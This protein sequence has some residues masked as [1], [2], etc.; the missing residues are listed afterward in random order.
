M[1]W[2]SWACTVV[3]GALGLMVVWRVI[4]HTAVLTPIGWSSWDDEGYFLITV[5]GV[6][7]GKPLYDETFSQYGP[8]YYLAELAFRSISAVPVTHETGRWEILAFW[9]AVATVT[10]W[11]TSKLAGSYGWALVVFAVVARHIVPWGA[12]PG[13]PQW[14]LLLLLTAAVGLSTGVDRPAALSGIRL[15]LIGALTAAV[16]LTKI[17]A[18]VY[19]AAGLVLALTLNRRGRWATA[20]YLSA[21]LGIAA[22]PLAIMRRHLA[23]DLTFAVVT[24]TSIVT[25]AVAAW[26][27]PSRTTLPRRAVGLTVAGLAM[28]SVGICVA[29]LLAG[30]SLRGLVDGV[31]VRPFRFAGQIWLPHD[32]PPGA[33][34]FSAGSLIACCILCAAVSRSGLTRFTA[35]ALVMARACA[36]VLI[37]FGGRYAM[38]CGVLLLWV[39]LLPP[40]REGADRFLFARATFAFTAAVEFLYSYPLPGYQLKW[41]TVLLL[42][43]GVL[44]LADLARDVSAMLPVLGKWNL[45]AGASQIAVLAHLIRVLPLPGSIGVLTLTPLDLPGARNLLVSAPGAARL[46]WITENL[47]AHCDTFVTMPGLNSY[48]FWTGLEP[49]TGMNES[50]WMILYD[51]AQ[52][53]RI[54]EALSSHQRPCAVRSAT[55]VA[56]WL[57]LRDGQ[58]Q[59]PDTL[60]LARFINEEFATA[61]VVGGQ[62]FRLPRTRDLRGFRNYALWG[63][64]HFDKGPVIRVPADVL[65]TPGA[66]TVEAW[67]RTQDAGVILGCQASFLLEG[68]PHASRPVFYVGRDGRLAGQLCTEPSCLI[69]TTDPVNDG[70]WH[71]VALVVASPKQLLY[72]DG[73][74]V[75][76]S[77]VGATVA[78]SDAC[79]LGTG[80]TSGWPLA[81]Q[82]WMPFRGEVADVSVIREA[83]MPADLR[84]DYDEG[85][86]S[87]VR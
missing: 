71:H 10:A 35:A 41:G 18:G 73:T 44:S 30:T 59:D 17:N 1:K 67:F 33:M 55:D 24:S 4:S 65:A 70:A 77:S 51:A 80:E 43:A 82:G 8:A 87:V 9:L 38:G 72:L 84:R 25:C 63:A 58:G 3:A 78:S 36:A 66:L 62:E 6:L 69:R 29:T 53:A 7:R 47:R 26:T 37:L 12:D 5:Q 57:G 50:E 20:A 32:F 27:R 48:Y 64:K 60:P 52:Q 31:I 39:I 61:A 83:R 40:A 79:Q 21:A 28:A 23:A 49:P 46:H 34:L 56:F 2:L 81:A 86:E 76:T 13:L 75:G 85:R 19:L 15:V 14:F 22:L 16:I 45:V 68:V 54:V 74:L 42:P 11:W